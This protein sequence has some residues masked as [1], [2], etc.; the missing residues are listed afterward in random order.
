M[1]ALSFA[2][3]F[4]VV[5]DCGLSPVLTRTGAQDQ[6]VVGR[7]LRRII[8]FKLLLACAVVP[9]VVMAGFIAGYA[10]SMLVL[11]ATASLVMVGDS[12]HLTLYAGLRSLQKF[13]YEAQGVVA[14]KIVV[15]LVGIPFILLKLPLPYLMLP[16]AASTLLNIGYACFVLRG[17][18]LGL[19][20]PRRVDPVKATSNTLPYSSAS[21]LYCG[22]LYYTVISADSV[23]LYIA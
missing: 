14:A 6:S 16:L 11:I 22:L 2:A 23:L 3:L 1:L 10:Y 8:G 18:A 13:Q 17:L 4:A 5:V 15:L 12:I 7:I 19:T 20:S 9:L 21:I